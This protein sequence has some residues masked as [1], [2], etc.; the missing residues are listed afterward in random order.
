MN[1]SVKLLASVLVLIPLTAVSAPYYTVD[2]DPPTTE[3][4]WKTSFID[5]T[6]SIL[7]AYEPTLSEF[8]N[9][10]PDGYVSVIA[11]VTS[12]GEA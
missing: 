8:N 10:T 3:D 9:V 11:N 6:T 7:A 5:G 12:F 1:V 4:F 2:T